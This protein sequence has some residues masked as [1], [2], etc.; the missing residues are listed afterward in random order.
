MQEDHRT[1]PSEGTRLGQHAAGGTSIASPPWL[2][3]NIGHVGCPSCWA[4]GAKLSVGISSD[5][6]VLV[7]VGALCHWFVGGTAGQWQRPGRAH[8]SAVR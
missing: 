6:H 4:K 5:R 2:C 3:M 8:P 1:Q 7:R